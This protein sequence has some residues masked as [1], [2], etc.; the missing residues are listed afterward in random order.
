MFRKEFVGSWIKGVLESFLE[1][2]F[3]RREGFRFGF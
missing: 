2:E 3:R 1:L